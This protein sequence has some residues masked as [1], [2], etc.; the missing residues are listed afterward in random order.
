MALVI[1]ASTAHLCSATL[2]RQDDV[3]EVVVAVVVAIQVAVEGRV[4]GSAGTVLGHGP[5]IG[6]ERNV[7]LGAVVHS[8][9]VTHPFKR[10]EHPH[11]SIMQ[12]TMSYQK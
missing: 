6:A 1:C 2:C 8:V 10:T 9:Y 7:G 5:A 4:L 12:K 3:A 11:V